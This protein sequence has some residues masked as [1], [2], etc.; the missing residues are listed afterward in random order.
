MPAVPDVT[1][2][3]LTSSSGAEVTPAPTTKSEAIT[4]FAETKRAFH[5]EAP[6]SER[7]DPLKGNEAAIIL[8]QVYARYYDAN[9]R[10]QAGQ[11]LS[12]IDLL[13]IKFIGTH[14][15][16]GLEQ[17]IKTAKEKKITVGPDDDLLAK[18]DIQI[19]SAERRV[20]SV[21]LLDTLYNLEAASGKEVVT[22]GTPLKRKV[23]I[24][25]PRKR[26]LGIEIG[27]RPTPYEIEYEVSTS[28]IL[29]DIKSS[30]RNIYSSPYAESSGF[31]RLNNQEQD[32]RLRQTADAL[33]TLLEQTSGIGRH[34]LSSE[35]YYLF[36]DI[37][38]AGKTILDEMFRGESIAKLSPDDQFRV[39]NLALERVANNYA[40]KDL[41]SIIEGR[42]KEKVAGKIGE[43]TGVDKYTGRLEKAKKVAARYKKS[44]DEYTKEVLYLDSTSATKTETIKVTEIEYTAAINA[45]DSAKKAFDDKKKEIAGQEREK[46]RL[47]DRKD[48]KIAVLINDHQ[49]KLDDIKGKIAA[50]ATDPNLTTD[51]ARESATRALIAEQKE[52]FGEISKLEREKTID[53]PDKIDEIENGTILISTQ[54]RD[55]LKEILDEKETEKNKYKLTQGSEEKRALGD[56]IDLVVTAAST[57]SEKVSGCY[58]I[59]QR[60]AMLSSFDQFRQHLGLSKE[61]LDDYQLGSAIIQSLGLRINPEL[62]TNPTE[63]ALIQQQIL[64]ALRVQTPATLAYDIV[65]QIIDHKLAAAEE[66]RPKDLAPLKASREWYREQTGFEKTQDALMKNEYI[67]GVNCVTRTFEIDGKRYAVVAKDG[68]NEIMAVSV[69][70]DGTYEVR[71]IS[72][73]GTRATNYTEEAIAEVQAIRNRIFTEIQYDTLAD[74]VRSGATD[75]PGGL[76][77]SRLSIGTD[78]EIL[79][80]L[81]PGIALTP[82]REYVKRLPNFPDAK[83]L[84]NHGRAELK[85]MEDL[86]T[87]LQTLEKTKHETKITTKENQTTIESVHYQNPNFQIVFDISE[88]GIKVKG[89]DKNASG[90]WENVP[91]NSGLA[92]ELSLDEFLALG[93]QDTDAFRR[94]TLSGIFNQFASLTPEERTG[95]SIESVRVDLRHND[96]AGHPVITR[97][98]CGVNEN[99]EFY[100][101]DIDHP[102]RGRMDLIYGFEFRETAYNAFTQY[103]ATNNDTIKNSIM[104]NPL[105]EIQ[106]ALAKRYL[107]AIQRRRVKP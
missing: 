105:L 67:P 12:D 68:K 60:T 21:I 13:T 16:F 62:L 30:G 54:E 99:G 35:R 4:P 52:I 98:E 22:T 55:K 49:N 82:I 19:G 58:D 32:R 74:R 15:D 106:S 43:T 39:R 61:T 86:S 102:S 69:K 6:I 53:I 14:G 34:L 66:G 75:I 70:D 88:T 96:N 20:M 38:L 50:V 63:Q 40:E 81:G 64:T 28:N 18:L 37:N 1:T 10:Q 11:K 91:L 87:K 97:M 17:A 84:I 89:Q 48:N 79:I 33:D 29:Y 103:D 31:T 45:Y 51:E 56:E 73:L 24:I 2:N 107:E 65:Y 94:R 26:F 5:P 101:S 25:P 90:N 78:R 36:D 8:N 7:I 57:L 23:E 44:T 72:S 104:A 77:K 76:P 85:N 3:A 83:A 92:P 95:L 27:K 9:A 41:K 46:N 42:T 80:S 71:W 47:I 93:N 59:N 100:V